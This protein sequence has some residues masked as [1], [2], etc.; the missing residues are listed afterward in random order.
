MTA[1]GPPRP[2]RPNR[3]GPVDGSPSV[4]VADE[5]ADT[6]DP[7]PVDDVTWTA[8][9]EAVL[10]D[11]GITGEAELSVLFVDEPHI[12]ELNARFM[13]KAEPTDVLSFPL[14]GELR[15]AG[16]WPDG[17]TSG[18]QAPPPDADDLPLLLGDVVICPAV[19]ARN[20]PDHAGTYDDEVALL[21]VHGILH[22]LG[23]DHAAPGEQARMWA[24]E[25]A[26][27]GTHWRPF[28]RDPWSA[29]P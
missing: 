11:E 17:G 23:H 26:L 24:R 22:V 1:P 27:L 25:Q 12:A 29:P 16:R 10:R 13:G 15:A 20:A 19:A 14:D 9:A 5:Q 8:L 4:F 3:H 28:T 2:P 6:A 7:H 21:L 18:P